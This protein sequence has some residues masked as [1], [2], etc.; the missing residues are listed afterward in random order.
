MEMR[1]PEFI[2]KRILAVCCCFCSHRD[3][4]TTNKYNG[5]VSLRDGK[6]GPR[7]A[8]RGSTRRAGFEATIT[9][10]KN[11]A[12]NAKNGIDDP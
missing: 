5:E 8:M 7:I 9:G 11:G 10:S 6:S 2:A 3:Y 12:H 4:R 1:G